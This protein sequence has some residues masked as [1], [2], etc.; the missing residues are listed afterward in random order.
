MDPTLFEN[1]P[2]DFQS[3]ASSGVVQ[4][5]QG[6]M[7]IGGLDLWYKPEEI[8]RGEIIRSATTAV[9]Q[10]Y[11]FR[12][13][14]VGTDTVNQDLPNDY[15]A[16]K[17]PQIAKDF[18]DTIKKT[19]QDQL[20][21]GYN[22]SA[23]M[24]GSEAQRY[25]WVSAA[26]FYRVLAAEATSV[27]AAL[28]AAVSVGGHN[29]NPEGLTSSL[30]SDDLIYYNANRA[31]TVGDQVQELYQNSVLPGIVQSS[32]AYQGGQFAANHAGDALDSVGLNL[33]RAGDTTDPLITASN[34]GHGLVTLAT[35][36]TIA[37]QVI[38]QGKLAKMA[39]GDMLPIILTILFVVGVFLGDILPSLPWVYFLFGTIAW[40]VH[41][42]EM[43]VSAQLWVAAHAA[44]E[45]S[46]H[47]SNLAAKGYNN[48]LYVML[49]PVLSIGGFVAAMS[50]NWIGMYMLNQLIGQQFMN[51]LG[52]G[53]GLL[54]HGIGTLVGF[55]FLYL[56]CAWIIVNTSFNLITAFPRTILNWLSTAE[57]GHNAFDNG[58]HQ[59]L[60]SG[61]G[62]LRSM[63]GPHRAVEVARRL[64][65]ARPSAKPGKDAGE[66][67]S[68]P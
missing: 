8:H 38:P 17:V 21:A 63:G 16:A 33:L 67:K 18:Q 57:P 62:V 66:P 68:E 46:N 9:A 54:T 20:Q 61:V 12:G 31:I 42:T 45:G 24:Y 30:P 50:I 3:F 7:V 11:Y 44:P 13:F 51:Q 2:A 60:G 55:A 56:A 41:V 5:H 23:T 43:F 39:T 49:Y 53:L 59:V 34:V 58:G 25:G 65:T 27:N 22:N 36:G 32:V 35:A 26:D 48:M 10:Q 28:N 29:L 6:D 40:L 52:G 47:T 15:A 4:Q 19:V 1:P 64:I 37:T 14:K